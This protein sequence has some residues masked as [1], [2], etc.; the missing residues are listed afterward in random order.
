MSGN[1]ILNTDDLLG[2]YRIGRLLGRGGMGEVYQ[3]AEAGSAFTVAI[4]VLL[5]EFLENNPAFKEKFLQEGQLACRI[6]HPNVVRVID[7]NFDPERNLCYLVMEYVSGG[8]IQNLLDR[9]ETLDWEWALTLAQKVAEA[10][11]A[12]EELN[13]VH[14]DIKPDNLMLTENGEVK[15]ADL[16]IAKAAGSS[17][18]E[19]QPCIVGTP[20]YISPEQ[21]RDSSIADCRSDI[22]SLGVTLYEVMTGKMAY[23]GSNIY[24]TLDMVRN[25]PVPDPRRINPEIPVPAANLVMKMMAKDPAERQQ[26]AAELLHEIRYLLD[27]GNRSRHRQVTGNSARLSAGER[28][29]L[30]ADVCDWLKRG[31]ILLLLLIAVIIVSNLEVKPW[32]TRETAPV[33]QEK[34]DALLA[35]AGAD[36]QECARIKVENG[37]LEKELPMPLCWKLFDALFRGNDIRN[38]EKY[39]SAGVWSSKSGKN[40]ELA[41]WLEQQSGNYLPQPGSFRTALRHAMENAGIQ[42]ATDDALMLAEATA[43]PDSSRRGFALGILQQMLQLKSSSRCAPEAAC[44]AIQSAISHAETSPEYFNDSMLLSDLQQLLV[45]LRG[46]GCADGIDTLEIPE[47]MRSLQQVVETTRP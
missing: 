8:S 16:G 41:Q 11:A 12:A 24:E 37:V 45:I 20:A 6:S 42:L 28:L 33:D 5:P 40:G 23:A 9:G 2:K 18:N 13:I 25:A 22:Y 26:S 38:V 4:K 3:A 27:S 34:V 19:E 21:S 7:A 14:R 39:L 29:T 31:A 1:G 35:Q 17:G 15:L 44:R 32:R 47:E 43:S 10:L 30:S 36:R 46:A